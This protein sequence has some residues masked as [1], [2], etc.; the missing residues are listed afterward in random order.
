MVATL[1][2][3]LW[4][5]E[6]EERKERKGERKKYIFFNVLNCHIGDIIIKYILILHIST[7]N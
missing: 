3:D 4:R 1:V 5:S 2:V 6:E 7:I